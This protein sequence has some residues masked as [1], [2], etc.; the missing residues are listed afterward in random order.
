MRPFSTLLA[1]YLGLLGEHVMFSDA[2]GDA[3][4]LLV[5]AYLVFLGYSCAN[6]FSCDNYAKGSADEQF[7][8]EVACVNYCKPFEKI[9]MYRCGMRYLRD[10]ASTF[11]FIAITVL[12]AHF[13]TAGAT[14]ADPEYC[15]D[16]NYVTK[17]ICTQIGG[18]PK[19]ECKT[20]VGIPENYTPW[21]QLT[22][23]DWAIT[24]CTES[25]TQHD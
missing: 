15:M 18:V 17:G 19:E 4:R 24:H 2:T 8:H 5:P 23:C 3:I 16:M 22:A 13:D 14:H 1:M 11:V 9:R 12:F 21:C 7:C 25:G 6:A 10:A 20:V